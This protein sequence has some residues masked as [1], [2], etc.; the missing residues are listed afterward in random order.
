MKTKARTKSMGSPAHAI[1][2]SLLSRQLE[3]IKVIRELVMRESPSQHKQ[4][5][6]VC[7]EYVAGLFRDV[8]GKVVRHR[9]ERFGDHMQADFDGGSGS[10]VMLL[11]HFDTVWDV[12][13]FETMP[14]REERGRLWGPGVLDMKTGIAQ[15]LFAIS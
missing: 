11:G 15:M 5:V 1:L 13:T 10:R 6:D 9:A 7:G 12:G 2:Q 4:A 14:F 3:M 8:G